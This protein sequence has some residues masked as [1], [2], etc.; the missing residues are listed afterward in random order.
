MGLVKTST[1]FFA[2]LF[3]TPCTSQLS[4]TADTPAPIADKPP[5]SQL[6]YASS[7]DV[8]TSITSDVPAP[9]TDT[10]AAIRALL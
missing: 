10:S 3:Y 6:L 9:K 8:T 4:T 2:V 5:S 7:P 1:V